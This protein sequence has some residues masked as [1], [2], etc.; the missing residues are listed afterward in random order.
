MSKTKFSFS[1]FFKDVEP[2]NVIYNEEWVTN[3]HFIFKKSILTKTLLKPLLKYPEGDMKK[4]NFVMDIVKDEKKNF[5]NESSEPILFV[6][7]LIFKVRLKNDIKD[8]LCVYNKK[9]NVTLRN[10][11][12]NFFTSRRCKIYKGTSKASPTIIVDKNLEFVGILLP[13]IVCDTTIRK[14]TNYDEYVE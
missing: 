7:D 8:R 10:D 13:A 12:Y 9:S 3:G 5:D 14:G 11:Y 1:S 6:P 2:K 4:L